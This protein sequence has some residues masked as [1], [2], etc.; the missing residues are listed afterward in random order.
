M[1]PLCNYL[2]YQGSDLSRSL[3]LFD[4]INKEELNE[5]GLDYLKIYLANLI[6][7]SSKT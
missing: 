4:P 6:G 2:S 5:Q 1:Y 3:L 7:L